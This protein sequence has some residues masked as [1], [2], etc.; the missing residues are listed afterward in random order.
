MLVFV[1]GGGFVTGSGNWPQWDTAKIVELSIQAGQPIVAVGIKSV[2]YLS[3]PLFPDRLGTGIFL[4]DSHCL[5]NWYSYRI[6]LFGFL[7]S[8]AMRKSGYL[9]NNGLH[10][11]KLAFRWIQK[12]ISGFGGDPQNVTFLGSSIGAG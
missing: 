5:R 8:A 2:L 9:P 3:T 12:Y 7:T 11:Q 6:G 1:H 4:K 10:D